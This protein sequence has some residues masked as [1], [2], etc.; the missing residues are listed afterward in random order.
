MGIVLSTLL[1]ADSLSRSSR[2]TLVSGGVRGRGVSTEAAC[3]AV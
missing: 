1:D 2:C 3:V